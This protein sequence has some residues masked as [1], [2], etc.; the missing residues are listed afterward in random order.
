MDNVDPCTRKTLEKY[1][2]DVFCS[3]TQGFCREIQKFNIPQTL[4]RK[5]INQ[6]TY[7][8]EVSQ[9]TSQSPQFF[10]VCVRH[11]NWNDKLKR[12][13]QK[14]SIFFSLLA[15]QIPQ[16]FK[17][18]TWRKFQKLKCYWSLKLFCMTLIS[19]TENSF[20]TFISEYSKIWRNCPTFI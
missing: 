8:P 18:F 10:K 12:R 3:V 4:F 19:L 17:V 1:R 13:F 15:K 16:K 2:C 20:E 14:M 11:L 9:K 5:P 6:V 7:V